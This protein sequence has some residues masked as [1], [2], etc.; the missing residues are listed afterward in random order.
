MFKRKSYRR[1]QIEMGHVEYRT[2]Y[3]VAIM[4]KKAIGG[5]TVLVIF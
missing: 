1:E 2:Y 4:S 5:T 3:L